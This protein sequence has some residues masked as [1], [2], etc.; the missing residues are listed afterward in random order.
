M[1]SLQGAPSQLLKMYMI[2]VMTQG[3]EFFGELQHGDRAQ[4][5]MLKLSSQRSTEGF[6]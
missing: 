2:Q 1:L 6:R 5:S 3:R 4:Q